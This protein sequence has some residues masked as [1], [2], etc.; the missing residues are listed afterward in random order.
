MYIKNCKYNV[1]PNVRFFKPT[2]LITNNTNGVYLL[3]WLLKFLVACIV[4]V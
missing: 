2:E 4:C 1:Y 3:R